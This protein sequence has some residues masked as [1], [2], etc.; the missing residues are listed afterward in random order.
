M[1]QRRFY[2]EESDLLKKLHGPFFPTDIRKEEKVRAI[3]TLE[4][5]G[6]K[7]ET[8]VW[9]LSPLGIELIPTHEYKIKKG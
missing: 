2:M 8:E 7:I 9:R 4:Q 6:K 5:T 1:N 3:L